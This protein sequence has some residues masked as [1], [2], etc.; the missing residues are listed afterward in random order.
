MKISFPVT[1]TVKYFKK[2]FWFAHHY[3]HNWYTIGQ[4]N[5]NIWQL[6][7]LNYLTLCI[8]WDEWVLFCNQCIRVWLFI[9]R[10]SQESGS[11]FFLFLIIFCASA[12]ELC[13]HK[14]VVGNVLSFVLVMLL[15]SLNSLPLICQ[16][17]HENLPTRSIFNY[18]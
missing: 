18:L 6:W 9:A 11:I 14:F 3:D 7:Q 5:I 12:G 10:M 4:N 16:R 1:I 2:M 8:S 17:S 15:N 13:S